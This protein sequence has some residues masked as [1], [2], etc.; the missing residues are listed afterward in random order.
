MLLRRSFPSSRLL[1][2]FAVA[3]CL[4]LGIRAACA[5]EKI[6]FEKQILPILDGACFKC[7]SAQ[8]KKVKGDIRLDD[9]AAVRAKSRSDNLVFPRKPEKSL[10]VKVIS[11]PA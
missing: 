2:G 8:A 9:V 10:L 6:D 5:E 4:V 11:L 7:H 1:H 3:L